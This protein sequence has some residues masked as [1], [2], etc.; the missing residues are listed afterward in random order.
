MRV[1]SLKNSECIINL[2]V[3]NWYIQ[4]SKKYYLYLMRF[5]VLIILFLISINGTYFAIS[6]DYLGANVENS[7][8]FKQHEDENFGFDAKDPNRVRFHLLFGG[9]KS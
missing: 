2:C 6:E 8:H 1:I 3:F 4:Y 5:S 7:V 9:Y